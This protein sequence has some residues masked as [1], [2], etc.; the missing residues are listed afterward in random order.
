MKRE[1]SVSDIMRACLNGNELRIE[2]FIELYTA[3]LR[4]SGNPGKH[5]D[6]NDTLRLYEETVKVNPAYFTKKSAF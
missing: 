6:T 5:V 2:T 4:E 3:G 1:F